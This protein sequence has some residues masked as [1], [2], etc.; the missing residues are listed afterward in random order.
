M[1]YT[2]FEWK[3]IENL[4]KYT[5]LLLGNGSSIAVSDKFSYVFLRD[6][7]NNTYLV[8]EE[9][10]LFHFFETNDFE[11]ILK[12]LWQANNVN[13]VLKVTDTK[14]QDAYNRVKNALIL[15]VRKIHP[16]YLDTFKQ[17]QYISNFLKNFKNIIS[18]NYDLILYWAIL[19]GNEQNNIFGD[20][21]INGQFDIKSMMQRNKIKI[22][23]P[24]GNLI[25]AY[26][27]LLNEIKL[28]SASN[29]LIASITEQ[30]ESG[31]YVPLFI[32]EGSSRQKIN[33]IKKSYYL[34]AVY[35][36]ILPNAMIINGNNHFNI[37][38]YSRLCEVYCKTIVIYGFDFGIQ[39][40]HIL[41]KIFSNHNRYMCIAIAIS[42]FNNDEKYCER[43]TNILSEYSQYIKIYF[44]D[45]SSK[46]CWNNP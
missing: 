37:Q 22:F 4:F 28:K 18:L 33:S 34:N 26:N 32:S 12:L 30:W 19:Y 14:T 46:G 35:E 9:K 40:K 38:R 25:L 21:F 17:L 11:E 16:E 36:N 44:F 8:Q 7:L 5:N 43:V 39:D 24:H 45:S 31:E 10:D 29:N 20:C 6:I 3:E 15:A 41:D 1:K 13:K 2:I 42:V 27:K 23:Y